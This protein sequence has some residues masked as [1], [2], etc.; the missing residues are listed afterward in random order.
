M[1]TNPRPLSTEST[2]T[3]ERI[4]TLCD[5]F[6]TEWLA[7]LRPRIEDYLSRVSEAVRDRL[8][9]ELLAV[10]VQCRCRAGEAV[11][12]AEYA[13]RFPGIPVELVQRLLGQ[14]QAAT[15]VPAGEAGPGNIAWGPHA[16]NA[17]ACRVALVT[18]S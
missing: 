17:S 14:A 10:E 12:A 6:E 2:E 13:K 5:E 1:N 18:E 9:H 11:A 4:D 16:A 8:L 3:V 15:V 7:G